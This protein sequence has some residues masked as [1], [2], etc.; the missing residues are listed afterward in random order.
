MV[1]LHP[2]RFMLVALHKEILR[3]D[4]LFIQIDELGT[5]CVQTPLLVL[6]RQP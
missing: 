6:E 5:Y 2:C 3:F 4:S 1:M